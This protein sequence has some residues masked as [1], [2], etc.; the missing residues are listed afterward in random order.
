MTANIAQKRVIKDLR[1]LDKDPL[2]EHGI[3]VLFNEYFYNCS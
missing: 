1:N 2:T 3:Y